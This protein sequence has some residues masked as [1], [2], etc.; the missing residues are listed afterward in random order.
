M[1]E[2]QLQARRERAQLRATLHSMRRKRDLAGFG[3]MIALALFWLPLLLPELSGVRMVMSA[4]AAVVLIGTAL[5]SLLA[6][7]PKCLG[8]YRDVSRLVSDPKLETPCKSCGFDMDKH[9]AMY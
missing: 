9:I 5:P 3:F 4:I 8:R 7:C 2:E 1:E 6:R